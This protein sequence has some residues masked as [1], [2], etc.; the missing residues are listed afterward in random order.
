MP[1][2]TKL[3]PFSTS[4]AYLAAKA[5]A[6]AAFGSWEM[7][8]EKVDLIPKVALHISTRTSLWIYNKTYFV[9]I[10][11][12]GPHGDEELEPYQVLGLKNEICM[13]IL[14][15][16]DCAVQPVGRVY[17]GDSLCGFIMPL[18]IEIVH[19][20]LSL[21]NIPESPA[22]SIP[23]P[24]QLIE[25]LTRL[26]SRLHAKGIIHGDIKPHNL[27]LSKD[28]SQ[29]LLCDFG[30]AALES[31]NR[32]PDSGTVHYNSPFRTLVSRAPLAK[33]DDIYMTGITIWEIYTGRVPFDYFDYDYLE[34]VIASGFQPDLLAVDDHDIRRLIA[35]YLEAGNP[36]MPEGRTLRGNCACVTARVAFTDCIAVP[37]HSYEKT[38]H[39]QECILEECE[40]P[41]LAPDLVSSVEK[42]KCSECSCQGVRELDKGVGRE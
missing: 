19:Q 30:S 36:S 14:A 41:Y 38:V 9:K 11:E 2:V 16:G 29:L 23:S 27:L 13:M 21:Y 32:P 1:P 7:D 26:V 3:T 17:N 33:A 15:G 22:G 39:R 37:P 42:V 24:R 4:M 12:N 31:G 10:L 34:D 18:G 25:E 20:T 40:D 5:R 35:S 28:S 8:K 6:C